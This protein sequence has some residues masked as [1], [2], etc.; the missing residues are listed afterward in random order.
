MGWA[1]FIIIVIGLIV[2]VCY[3]C[4]ERSEE[5]RKKRE[6]ARK[7]REKLN[8]HIATAD[9]IDKKLQQDINNIPK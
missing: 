9:R 1:I 6:V 3:K 7:E 8:I 5:Q 2:F 4:Y